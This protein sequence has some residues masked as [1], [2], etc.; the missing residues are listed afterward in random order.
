MERLLHEGADP[1]HADH[2][3]RTPIF[4]A[5]DR[6]SIKLLMAC[7]ADM[8]K[9]DKNGIS[10]CD[11]YIE[12]KT[13][14]LGAIQYCQEIGIIPASEVT[15]SPYFTQM[16][17]VQDKVAT[18][19]LQ[20][21]YD[22]YNLCNE[23]CWNHLLPKNCVV[24]FGVK[25]VIKSALAE[26]KKKLFHAFGTKINEICFNIN[27]TWDSDGFVK[28]VCSTGIETLF[29]GKTQFRYF[30][31]RCLVDISSQQVSTEWLQG[32]EGRI[33]TFLTDYKR[34]ISKIV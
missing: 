14:F 25:R 29:R 22:V 18:A 15:T 11:F 32:G 31:I 26:A 6:F 10:V 30:F 33:L 8:T 17:L 28:T 34:T 16:K 13:G 12:N 7:Q 5:S 23:I 19:S 9:K 3:G 24:S 4:N 27:E 1:N 20:R 2:T 21:V